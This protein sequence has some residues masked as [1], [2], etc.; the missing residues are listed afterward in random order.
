M[1]FLQR[2][3]NGGGRV[4]REMAVGRGRADLVVEF[5]PDRF[6]LELKLNTRP[7]AEAKGRVQLVRYLD[8]LG[9]DH[10]YLLLFETDPAIPWDA[11]LRWEEVQEGDRRI[12]LIG[13]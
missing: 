13:L 8:R 10:G 1:A 5:G 11:R 7:D 3:V 4:E 12:T 6:A 9:L 2:I